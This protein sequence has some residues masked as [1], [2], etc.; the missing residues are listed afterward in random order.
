[1]RLA[2]YTKPLL[3]LLEGA[4]YDSQFTATLSVFIN[5]NPSEITSS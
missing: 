5:T 1:M 4:P 3:P 2:T